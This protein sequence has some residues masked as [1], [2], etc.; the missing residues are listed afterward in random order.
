MKSATLSIA[1]MLLAAAS[2]SLGPPWLPPW[3]E[4]L[5]WSLVHSTWQ[6]AALGLLAALLLRVAR[7]QSSNT[8][9]AFGVVLLGLM[10]VAPVATWCVLSAQPPQD[11]PLVAAAPGVA[12][13]GRNEPG[14]IRALPADPIPSNDG[15]DA[16][17]TPA[18]P[19]R[20][21]ATPPPA[22]QVVESSAAGWFEST[23]HAWMQIGDQ[24]SPRLPLLVALWS[25]GVALCSLRP[26][27]G[28]W[29][30]WRLQSRGLA[31]VPLALQS[32]LRELS[33]RMGV[34]R[35]VRIAESA[36]VNVPLVVGYL[37]PIVLLPASVL[38]GLPAPQLEAVLAHEL[39]HIRR[40][41]WVVNALQVLVE[42]L[43]FYHPA[44]WWLSRRVHHEREL[45][46]DDL[47]LAVV[48][49]RATYG[50]A[51][52]ALEQLRQ[53]A[54]T[55]LLAATGGQ[56]VARVRRLL[57]QEPRTADAPRRWIGG[58]SLI[59]VLATVGAAGLLLQSSTQI[60]NDDVPSISSTTN[61]ADEPVAK[62]LRQ[63][64]ILL[65]DHWI[66]QAVEFDREG[67]E[68]ATASL[69]GGVTLRRWDMAGLKL[70]S[71]I[72]L[73][74]DKHGRAFREGTLRFAADRTRV[75]A[76]TDEYVGIWDAITGQLLRQLPFATKD[77]I[78]DCA[79]DQLDCTPDLS[80][81]VGHRALPGRL[82]LSYDALVL[83][84]DGR[85]G[86]SLPSITD[87]GAT[88]LVSLDLTT[89]GAQLVTT[90]GGGAKVWDVKT[91]RLLRT[92]AN[93]DNHV[94]SVRFSPDGRQLAVGDILSVKLFDATSG[95]L[96]RQLEGAYRYSSSRSPN[97]V[98]SRDGRWLARL[99][100]QEA[101]AGETDK[102]RYVVPIWS[103]ETGAKSFVLDTE[104]ND[105]DF[106]NDGRRLAVAFS[107]MQQALSVWQL[108]GADGASLPHAPAE[109]KPPA[110]PGPHSR[111]DR[112]EE[113]GH[114]RGAE[115]AKFI[116]RFQPTWGE[117]T[118][119]LQYGIAFT[120]Q[121]AQFQRGERVP[122]A[123]FFRNA[124]DKPLK[125]ETSP[126]YLGNPPTLVNA[127][128]E[129]LALETIPLLGTVARY[130][131][132]L[133]P[134]EALGPFYSNIA[135]GD[136]PR[137]HQQHWSPV[138]RVAEPG[139]Y[140]VYHT[141]PIGRYAADVKDGQTERIAT[142][143]VEFEL[144]A[145]KT[146]EP[147]EAK[148]QLGQIKLAPKKRQ[149]Q[150]QP[151]PESFQKH[152][153]QGVSANY[154][155]DGQVISIYLGRPTTDAMLAEL[156]SLPRLRELHLETTQ[157]VT[158][159]GISH[160]SKLT[161]LEK[162]SFY[163]VNERGAD[164]G[165][166]VIRSVSGL[167]SLRELS[168]GEC[169][170]TDEGCQ[171]LAG[172]KQLVSLSL[173]QEGR[174]TDAAL[175][176][177]GTLKQL[178]SLSLASVVATQRLG[179]MRFT[180][181]GLAS[182]RGL[183]ELRAL[184]L[185]GHPVSA[186]VLVSNK[187]HDVSLGHPSV[188]DA[189]AMRLAELADLRQLQLS[190]TSITDEGLRKLAGLQQLQQLDVG[191]DVVS[192]AGVAAFERHPNLR[193]FSLRL[194]KLSDGGVKS[195]ATIPGL[196]NVSLWA[197]PRL[198]GGP[199]PA[200]LT[201]DGLRPL[202]AAANLHTL[203]LVNWKS[204]GSWLVLKEFQQ[205][206]VLS[207]LM[208]DI[209]SSEVEALDEALPETQI[210]PATGGGGVLK[211]TTDAKVSGRVVDGEGQPVPGF[212]FVSREGSV[213]ATSDEQGEF[214][215]D[216]PRSRATRALLGYCPGFQP[217]YGAPK[218]GDVLRIQLRRK[219]TQDRTT[220]RRR[221]EVRLIDSITA[222]PVPGLEVAA[223][224]WEGPR[225]KETAGTAI[226]NEDGAAVFEGLE[227]VQHRLVLR[228]DRRGSLRDFG[229]N[230][231]YVST[232]RYPSAD[233]QEVAML[234]DRACEL[235]LRAVDSV[236]GQGIAGVRFEREN[237]AGELWQQAIVPE[238]LGADPADHPQA[239]DA[240]GNFRCRVRAGRWNYMVGKFAE[241]YSAII[242]IDGRQEVELETPIGGR[243]A[244]TFRL[245]KDK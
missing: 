17:P 173:H 49:D 116:E 190:F 234:V 14:T 96:L 204:R 2:P 65:P 27:L 39:A 192:D 59:V 106:S 5:G 122:L 132:T 46:C 90:N 130:V 88:D 53:T 107:D 227:F 164:L 187:L 112:V 72:K 209:S 225:N 165:D 224:C 181:E 118:L 141:A 205:L 95:R 52:L 152:D 75:V 42:T 176:P 175:E 245:V 213:P 29:M 22:M 210:S 159:E 56:L 137:P 11:G 162:A 161:Q 222:Q 84:W 131:E 98:F 239:T 177:I 91:G 109:Q 153:G 149:A 123:Y 10:V 233:E 45:C 47:A 74:A 241:G 218:P 33:K 12:T 214:R 143:A 80:V 115:A 229:P 30:H 111:Q 63:P 238:Q 92:F 97:L 60:I 37:R 221:M 28:L 1:A 183:T 232:D 220:G 201:V 21:A 236:T 202:A 19:P 242:P 43:L 68:L 163:N 207:F 32:Q 44:V 191:S 134:G 166:A 147:A 129:K 54:P 179:R 212:Q 85:S 71:E 136:N 140:R 160:L 156:A 103:T 128:G 203:S 117:T 58:L 104:A 23:H 169:G 83:A 158:A 41:D 167:P 188:D 244:Y 105:A 178:Q 108:A 185:H 3:A 144:V 69:Q 226:A 193:H 13:R 48:G 138:L 237:A 79:I 189:V 217:W 211:P 121:P 66:M 235:T 20:I 119:G 31:A 73:Q 125:F 223:V 7:S 127:N 194:S 26:L 100:T 219:S 195:I 199:E 228:E 135:L 184:N 25:L 215:F 113:N 38:T 186:D 8:R 171:V 15:P 150:G 62:T 64:Q 99:G 77:G 76:A 133:Q 40:H 182:L 124:S 231:S 81:I 18:S 82:T 208:C 61:A 168:V 154:D 51:L 200:F 206:K 148:K 155:E 16:G 145:A 93:D 86:E 70:R 55:P 146:E 101:L 34:R 126:D 157:E 170:T 139:K 142:P 57:P 89:D 50:R 243:V 174:L 110:G 180:A 198:E 114:Y 9:Y 240:N 172:M 120:K 102:H 67:Q 230:P 197:A 36:L 196:T 24:I 78:Y 94:W 87:E 151:L 35:A 4:R 6:L 216:W